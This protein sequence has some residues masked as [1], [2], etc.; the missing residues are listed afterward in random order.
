[1]TGKI[2]KVRAAMTT[3]FDDV[4]AFC[5]GRGKDAKTREIKRRRRHWLQEMAPRGLKVIL[6]IEP[7]PPRAIDFGG[8][9]VSR[10]ELTLLA[11]GLVVGLLEYVPIEETLYPVEGRGYLFVDCLW[12]MRPYVGRGVGRAL[13]DGV[14]RHARGNDS[15][16]ATVAWRGADPAHDWS[17]MPAAFFRSF[18]FDAVDEEGDRVLMAVSYGA[19]GKP[20][21]VPLRPFEYDGVTFLCHPSCPASLWAAET[22]RGIPGRVEAGNVK[23]VEVEDREDSRRYGA[24]FGV[25]VEGRVTVNRLAFANDVEDGL[26]RRESDRSTDG[27]GP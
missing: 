14:I 4:A 25:C 5:A 6:A 1:L 15:G 20:A 3:E 21:L 26:K 11:D 17:Y 9:R 22:V 10:D 7:R 8:E 23:I 16:V 27:A 12:V 13:M 24:L 2:V 18:G 19:R